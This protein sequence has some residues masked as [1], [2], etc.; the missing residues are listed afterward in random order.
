[1][2][3]ALA[4][5]VGAALLGR[6]S[7]EPGPALAVASLSGTAGDALQG[8]A[9][10]LPFGY[11]FAAG[12]AAAVNPCGFAL[13]PGYLGLYLST[14]A[15]TGRPGLGRA[16]VVGVTMTASFVALFGLLGLV[17]ATIASV[18]VTVLPLAS[19]LVGL[20]LVLLGG[21]LLAGG[22]VNTGPAE[23]L[24]GRV[25]RRAGRS[26]LLGYAAY[27]TA[28]GLTSLACTLPL[29]LSVVGTA[30]VAGGLR[31]GLLQFVLYGLG[32]GLVVTGATLLVALF[33]HTL[34]SRIGQAGRWLEPAGAVLLLVAGAYVVYYWLT[35]GGLLGA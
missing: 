7:G 21:R 14:S 32:M 29:F 8:I 10:A 27:G 34:L 13:L 35:V 3:V 11:A 17:L 4:V 28:F 30:F 19:L 9:D 22:S 12:L 1:V 6:S 23:R 18:L 31:A 5:A 2:V 24:G 25:G 16:L 33:G 15:G 26:G 20:L